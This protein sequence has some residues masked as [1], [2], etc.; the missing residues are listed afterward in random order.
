MCSTGR[1]MKHRVHLRYVPSTFLI[2]LLAITAGESQSDVRQP[3]D[4]SAIEP[5]AWLNDSGIREA[6]FGRVTFRS[7][8]GR[9]LSARTY[10]AT[11][12][13]P[14][15][16]PILFVMHGTKRDAD[17]Y[18]AAAAP[19]A[20]R[21]AVLA[22]AIEFSRR[23]YPSG[24][25][26]TLGVTT[27]GPVTQQALAEGR[28][29]NPDDYLYVEIERAFEAVRRS[30]DGRQ[31]GYYLF[32]HSAGA[33][34]V[35]R[36]LTFTPDARVLGAVAANAGWYT[37]PTR[38]KTARFAMPYGLQGTPLDSTD[39]GKLLAAPLTVLLG[40]R[41][42]TVAGDDRLVRNTPEA[43]AQGLTRV[44]RG[45]TYFET[46]RAVARALGTSFG[47]R[48]VSAPGAGH[49]VREVI[50]SAG[51]LLFAPGHASCD[52]TAGDGAQGLVINEILADPPGDTNG[53]GLRSPVDDEFVEFVNA[54]KTPLC[55]TGWT[56]SDAQQRR[57]LFP[58]GPTLAPGRALI[59]FGGGI[60]TGDFAGAEVQWASSATGLSLSNNGDVL[61]LRDADDRVVRQVSWGDCAGHLCAVDHWRGSLALAGS[62]VRW[63]EP[64]GE[65][66]IHHDVA[67]FGLSP[68]PR[69]DGTGWK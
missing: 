52:S 68:G 48:L 30:L 26:Y 29:R 5:A 12:F 17:R 60:P 23:D 33:Q 67:S 50:A 34:F 10:R 15:S 38:G 13:D 46:G 57:H 69:T 39:V 16:G 37:L 44:A 47:W 32:G 53:D 59:L 4:T 25:D 65:F 7:N 20:E 51:T 54:G 28:W 1:G 35:H 8:D 9:Q 42:T 11:R 64:L 41:D 14:Q 6:G 40:S 49:D 27:R 61:T 24:D 55:L 3:H 22:V 43:R 45:Q 62:V 63:P 19:V 66:K 58:V 21:Y 31:T 36:L 2:C 18:L 56:L